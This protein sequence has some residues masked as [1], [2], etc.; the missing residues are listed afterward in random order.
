MRS[1][2]RHAGCLLTASLLAAPGLAP[3]AV[4]QSQPQVQAFDF[5]LAPRPVAA[6]ANEV[7]RI[8]G[9]TVIFAGDAPAG[10]TSN[11][12]RGRM[13]AD[14]ALATLLAGTELI[15]AFTAAGAVRIEALPDAAALGQDGGQDDEQV[16]LSPIIVQRK[17]AFSGAV[18]GFLAPAT[19]TGVKSGVPL[20]EVPQSISVVTSGEL[21][22]RQPV[23]IEDAVKYTAGVN[24]STWGVD[25]RYDQFAIRGFDLGTGSIYRDGLPQKASSFSA[26]STDPYMTERIDV[27]RGPAG[28]LYGSND[29]GGMINLVT[30]R[31][32]FDHLGEASV[33]YGSNDTA[34]AAFDWSDSLNEAGSIAGRLTGLLRRGETEYDN[35]DNDRAFLAGGLTLAPTESTVFTLLAHVQQDALSP[36]V[37]FP[38]AGEDYDA[39]FGRLP[40]DWGYAQSDYNRFETEQQS[41]GWEL[42]HEFSEALSFN[43]RLR[44]AHQTTDYAQLDYSHA[45]AKGVRYYPFLVE[46]DAQ[47]LGL[48]NNFEWK[49]RFG[50]AENSLIVGGD[51]QK[52]ENDAQVY[53]DYKTYLVGYADPSLDFAV[54]DPALSTDEK[55]A[56]TEYGI[57]FQDHLKFDN[58]TSLT[59]GLRHAWMENEIRDQVGGGVSAQSNDATTGMIGATHE[60]ENGLAPYVSYTQGF[61]Q[62]VGKTIDGNVL[63]PSESRQWEAGLRYAPTRDLLLSAAV[64][65]LRKTNVKDYD[66]N[67]PTWSSF[68]QAGEIRSRGVEFEARGR[69]AERLQGVA[70]YA[71]LDTEII[72]SADPSLIGNENAMAPAHQISAWLDYDARALLPG[73]SFGAG[74]RYVSDA[75]STQANARKTPGYALA[76]LA[77]RYD[78]GDYGLDLSVSNLFDKDYYGVCYDYYGCAMGEG[79]R[80]TLRLTR[81]F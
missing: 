44:Y 40:G 59:F 64:F 53:L 77:V 68:T 3:V 60:F 70:S 11:A 26:F 51:Y 65:D 72:R 14:E 80:I 46:E 48:D 1:R 63:D 71:F 47:T 81:G 19:E 49:R 74:V 13:T 73:L 31:P 78:A 67:D 57:Y 7:G 32:T 41:V 66:L 36:L 16:A 39:A 69:I 55:V 20:S 79:R 34:T 54:V 4:A 35:S 28:V 12:V 29:A 56:Y 61:Q 17:L 5:D 37:M 27:L 58:G 23:Q 76:D 75:Y 15:H 30:K 50:P 52:T 33:S 38:V 2:F 18:D 24:A 6:A 45:T 8:A 10:A 22:A 21:E 25:D 9:L 62:N 42:T 43:H